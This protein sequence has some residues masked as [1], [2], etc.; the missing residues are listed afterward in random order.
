MALP[1]TMSLHAHTYL[2]L[3]GRGFWEDLASKHLWMSQLFEYTWLIRPDDDA[4]LAA[5]QAGICELLKSG[6]TTYAELYCPMPPFPRW[7]ETLGASGI[8]A[9]PCP[10]VQSGEWY[11]NDGKEVLYRWFDDATIDRNFK[12]ALEIIDEA[13]RHDSGRLTGMI[14]AAQVDTCTAELLKMSMTAAEQRNI[15]MQVH[16]SQ[17][18]FEFREIVK[19]H[20]MTPSSGWIAWGFS[21]RT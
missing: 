4:A 1:G 2:E 6:C 9:Y 17:S 16:A 21:I 11:T 19:R 20:N 5:T 14:G 12:Q 7:I 13:D 15:P 10:M 18:V 3:P 8:R